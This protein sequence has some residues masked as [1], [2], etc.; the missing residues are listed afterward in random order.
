MFRLQLDSCIEIGIGEHG[1][2][3]RIQ[4]QTEQAMIDISRQIRA[5]PVG[6]VRVLGRNER[7]Q[8]VVVSFGRGAP[9]NRFVELD[10]QWKTH[11]KKPVGIFVYTESTT[12]TEQA[13]GEVHAFY[14]RPEVFQE[15]QLLVLD[16]RFGIDVAVEDIVV[17]RTIGLHVF[18]DN[19]R[20]GTFFQR[21]PKTRKEI[22]DS[23]L[24]V[25]CRFTQLFRCI[26]VQ[27]VLLTNLGGHIEFLHG[28]ED[29]VGKGLTVLRIFAMVEHTDCLLDVGLVVQ[30]V[31]AKPWNP[32]DVIRESIAGLCFQRRLVVVRENAGSIGSPVFILVIRLGV[33]FK[34]RIVLVV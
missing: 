18:F 3:D 7:L 29:V 16:R 27:T 21:F 34:N 9:A 28:R 12:D 2:H 26:L 30:R 6:Y 32:E 17:V 25:R 33:K 15:L 1:A 14:V 8:P 19:V 24:A 10:R 22:H 4:S 13:C 20:F 23:P 31:S 11:A 5:E